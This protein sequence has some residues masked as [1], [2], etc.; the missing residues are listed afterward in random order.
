MGSRGMLGSDLLAQLLTSGY[1]AIGLHRHN[2]NFQKLDNSSLELLNSFDILINCI[3]MT[4]VEH[5]ER[6]QDLAYATN[7]VLPTRLAAALKSDSSRFIHVSSDYVF[8]GKKTTPYQPNDMKNPINVYGKSK[9]EGEDRLLN[10]RPNTQVVRTSW[11]YGESGNSF[12]KKVISALNRDEEIEVVDD[13]FGAPTHTSDLARFIMNLIGSGSQERITHGTSTGSASWFEFAQLIQR[14]VQKGS[15]K[16]ISSRDALTL[17]NRPPYSVLCSSEINGWS[18]PS[19]EG[20]WHKASAK[21]ISDSAP[22]ARSVNANSS[23]S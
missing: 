4:N 6:D 3:A 19:W 16:P 20:A 18:M 15:V 7:V 8:D 13:Q 14:D 21:F 17:A 11:L 23:N 5:A 9:S 12:P 2:F 1:D 22:R 10:M